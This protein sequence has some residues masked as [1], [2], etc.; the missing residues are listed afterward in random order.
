MKKKV[1]FEISEKQSNWINSLIKQNEVE[2]L[3]SYIKSLIDK[4]MSLN[5]KWINVFKAI[6]DR[7][8]KEENL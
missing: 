3:E 4:D 8:K 6:D 1:T 7:I 5:D 2:D